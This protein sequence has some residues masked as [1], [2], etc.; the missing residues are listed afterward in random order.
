MTQT[1]LMKG[2]VLVLAMIVVALLVS[3]H[4]QTAEA[5]LRVPSDSWNSPSNDGFVHHPVIDPNIDPLTGLPFW[6]GNPEKKLLDTLDAAAP[7][8][9][10]T[11]MPMSAP[12]PEPQA[13]SSQLPTTSSEVAPAPAPAPKA[14]AKLP[15]TGADDALMFVLIAAAL[16]VIGGLPTVGRLVI[17]NARC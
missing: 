15:D 14:E 5:Q 4:P 12:A 2:R 1:L 13:V 11:Y 6:Y 10:N 16:L 7:E 9:D 17:R 8:Q 3:V